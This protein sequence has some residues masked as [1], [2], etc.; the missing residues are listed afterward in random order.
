MKT[1]ILT[2]ILATL[3]M[4]TATA[5]PTDR[6]NVSCLDMNSGMPS[7]YVDDMMR[8]SNGFVWICNYGGGLLRYDGYGFVPPVVGRG[9]MAVGSYSCRTV[10]EDRFKRLWA[11]FDDGTQIISL[12]TRQSIVLK[13]RGRDISHILR[14]SAVRVCTDSKGAVW[15]AT[16]AYIYYITFNAN[17]TIKKILSRTYRGNVPDMVVKDLDRDGSI[18]ITIDGG[19][20]RL[21]PVGNRL[22]RTEVDPAFREAAAWFVTDITLM[23]GRTWIATNNGL[24]SYDRTT[25]AMRH[26]SSWSTEPGATLSHN[27]VSCLAPTSDG[28][29][30]VG[31]LRGV[32]LL[33]TRTNNVSNWTGRPET[34]PLNSGFINCM[35]LLGSQI[36]VGTETQGIIR[37]TPGELDMRQYTHTDDPASLSPNCVNAMFVEP[38]GTLW[39]GTV[40]GGLNRRASGSTGFRHF[41]TRNSALS[42]NSVST[43]TADN[44]RRL[45]VGTWGE[46]V[47]IVNMDA[48][49]QVQ[50]L[51]VDAGHQDRIK[52]IGALAYDP[53][54]DGMW[55]GANEGLY[56][57]DYKTRKIEE[58]FEGCRDIRGCIGSII[59]HNG[60]LWVGCIYGAV[61]V[62]LHRKRAGKGSKGDL[63]EHTMHNY[64]M[65]DPESRV[66]EKLSCFLQTRD[67]TLW[68]GSNEYGLY[69]RVK[70]K[71][72]RTSF[73][74]YTM[75]DGLV[76]NSVKGLVEDNRGMLWVAT[77]NGLSRLN[78]RTGVFSNY[79]VDDG[80]ISNQFYWNGAVR[81]ASGVLFFGT[82]KGLVELHGYDASVW[83]HSGQMRFTRLLV[84]NDEI[85]AGSKYLDD[86][87][88]T[89]RRLTLHEWNKSVEIEFSALKYYHEKTG[90]YS[91]RLKGFE[92]EWQQLPPGRHSARYTN[93]PSG[94]FTFEVRY[95]SGDTA[96]ETDTASI[97]VNVIPLFY[98]RPLFIVALILAALFAAVYIYKRHIERLRRRQADALLDPIRRTLSDTEE[99][100]LLRKR[101]QNI[102]DN[103]NRYKESYVKTARS[104]DDEKAKKTEPFMAKVIRIMEQNYQNSDFGV[105]ELSSR[106][107]MSRVMLSK[108]LNV[109]TGLSTSK[110][111]N[112][113]RLNI[114]RELLLKNSA[115]R[116][117]AE[118]AFSVGFNDPKYFTRCFTREYGVSPN[119]YTK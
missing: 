2:I 77:T 69:R 80:L 106:M 24:Y 115:N 98:K 99:P 96:A 111:M 116:N 1:L 76:N 5:L 52:F 114:A 81:S 58:P 117:I 74:A 29:L 71:N 85:L 37:L 55:I 3:N 101:I 113:Y 26:Y 70:N 65:S 102:L 17:G 64:K 31:T 7:N 21:R 92:D 91:Y 30:L 63:F 43:L 110:F 13:Y 54:N 19:L 53:I 78:P 48:P 40:D 6:Y 44:S 46:G 20:F 95:S 83:K 90:T 9:S 42:H 36:W 33:D 39:V 12:R 28:T 14:Q 10:C 34:D 82:A 4:L 22:V 88:S 38:D 97:A 25:R 105:A 62:N 94:S 119:K 107:G 8:D 112:N 75:Q 61:E 60:T 103:Q 68:L 108:K 47:N 56:F 89:A 11:A 27:F 59:E 41:T 104:N 100:M 32:N 67:G 87:I 50:R 109:E 18:W 79:T 23:A 86:D 35:M 73:H 15:L 93:L 49:G 118:I 57:Y 51:T 45:W 72:G 66:I 16:R 84:D